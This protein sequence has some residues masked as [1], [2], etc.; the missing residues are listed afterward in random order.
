MLRLPPG[1]CRKHLNQVSAGQ[2]LFYSSDDVLRFERFSVVLPDV[3]VRDESGLCP[4][5]TGELAA[6][7]VLDDHSR[8]V[9]AEDLG[10]FRYIERAQKLDLKVIGG[11]PFVIQRPAPLGDPAPGG[12]PADKRHVSIG[13]AFQ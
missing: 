6:E 11:D 12:P 7:I 10:D 5:V 2:D 3:A 1:F 8:L 13:W 4:Q 9:L